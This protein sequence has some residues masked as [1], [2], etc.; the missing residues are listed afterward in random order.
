MRLKIL[1]MPPLPALK[2]WFTPGEECISV[3][4]LKTALAREVLAFNSKNASA[5]DLVLDGFELLEASP[6]LDVLRDGDLL[7]VK[8]AEKT[9]EIGK[10]RKRSAS[11][12]RPSDK[13]TR[14]IPPPRALSS[15]SSSSASSSSS[16]SSS[17]SASSST[18][19]SS[20]SD[21]DSETPGSFAAPPAPAIYRRT[22]VPQTQTARRSSTHPPLKCND[23]KKV[24]VPP[25]K[26]KP[27][28][29]SRNQRRRLKQIAN[30]TASAPLPDF[31]STT[32]ATP[33]AKPET[34]A[35]RRVKAR[36]SRVHGP[37]PDVASALNSAFGG[38]DQAGRLDPGALDASPESA[39]STVHTPLYPP[40]E[41]EEMLNVQM[42]SMIPKSKN[43]NKSR[44][45]GEEIDPRSRKIVFGTPPPE[46]TPREANEEASVHRAMLIPPSALPEHL[47]PSNVFITSIDVE[48][49][50]KKAKKK[51]RRVQEPEIWDEPVLE[52]PVLDYG[53]KEGLGMDVEAPCTVNL[54]LSAIDFDAA[55][56]ITS[57]AQL[58]K[59]C[60]IGFKGLLMNLKTFSPEISKRYGRVLNWVEGNTV[61]IRPVLEGEE[62]DTDD[63]EELEWKEVQGQWRLVQ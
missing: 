55:P 19:S 14:S 43:K 5:L 62:E 27:S 52:T 4:N 54:K 34:E 47:V 28:T 17:S 41:A 21:S 1:S 61:T 23:S 60:I 51:K 37:A 57:H 15:S 12:I 50:L 46:E 49:G 8:P 26:G 29:H 38:N 6:L 31:V 40:S 42:M 56:L 13:K 53:E 10:K 48:E 39:S 25:G 35:E 3:A 45:G 32:N 7:V 36:Q 30:K 20:E 9:P 2:V 33:M 16:S 22:S 63:D 44:R 11:P 58:T 59:G 18:T 24:M